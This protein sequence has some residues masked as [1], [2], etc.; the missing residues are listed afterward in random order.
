MWTKKMLGRVKFETRSPANNKRN[1]GTEGE[2]ETT[3]E[4]GT[5]KTKV[6]RGQKREQILRTTAE[7]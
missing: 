2:A 7:G 3:G 6:E 4:G 1:N 5:V